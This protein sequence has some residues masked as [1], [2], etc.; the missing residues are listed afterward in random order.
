MLQDKMISGWDHTCTK[1]IAVPWSSLQQGHMAISRHCRKPDNPLYSSSLANPLCPQKAPE[2]LG[3]EW[4]REKSFCY[5]KNKKQEKKLY[6]YASYRS[7]YR[8]GLGLICQRKHGTAELSLGKHQLLMVLAFSQ[9]RAVWKYTGGRD[10]EQTHKTR[11]LRFG[12][13][14]RGD[15]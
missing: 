3:T 5:T 7:G 14:V 12:T 8:K 9:N 11:P 13:N 4:T 10:R 6:W 1:A 2:R 15:F